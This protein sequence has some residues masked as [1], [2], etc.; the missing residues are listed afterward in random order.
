MSLL[1]LL[2]KYPHA[3]RLR[4]QCI[5]AIAGKKLLQ[6]MTPRAQVPDMDI[7]FAKMTREG[8]EARLVHQGLDIAY[9]AHR[10]EVLDIYRPTGLSKPP[11]WVFLHGGYLLAGFYQRS[12]C[13][14]LSGYGGRRLCSCQYGLSSCA[15]NQSST[16]DYSCT[17]RTEFSCR[18][19]RCLGCRCKSNAYSWPFRWWA[20]GRIFGL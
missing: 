12:T 5:V 13:T 14:V 20:L 17:L 10:D 18:S 1:R 9:G 11:L 19:G 6:Q 15:S 7:L 2:P 8:N 4:S 16:N 3:H